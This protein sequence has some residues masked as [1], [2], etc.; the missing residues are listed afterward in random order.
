MGE[1]ENKNT[2][3]HGQFFAI[4]GQKM[5]KISIFMKNFFS[6]ISFMSNFGPTGMEKMQL[7]IIRLQCITKMV[8]NC[9]NWQFWQILCTYLVM[10]YSPNAKKHSS[11]PV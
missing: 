10:S 9:E 2:F 7:Q 3:V 5:L 8:K 6:Q 1:N 4:F 11:G